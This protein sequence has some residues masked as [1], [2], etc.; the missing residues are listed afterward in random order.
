MN[1][2]KSYV[3]YNTRWIMG[4]EEHL[5]L[6]KVEFKGWKQNSFETEEEAIQTLIDDDLTYQDYLI[7]R[8]VYIN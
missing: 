6:S 5:S 3:V 2:H 4:N 8:Q 7:L 1:I